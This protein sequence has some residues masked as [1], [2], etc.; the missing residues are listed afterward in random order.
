MHRPALTRDPYLVLIL[1]LAALFAAVPA[2]RAAAEDSG[3]ASAYIAGD[4]FGEEKPYYCGPAAVQTALQRRLKAVPPGQ[5]QIAATLTTNTGGTDSVR[6]IMWGLNTYGNTDWYHAMTVNSPMTATQSQAWRND[7]VYNIDHGYPVVVNLVGLPGSHPPNWPNREVYHYV[8]VVGYF[9]FGRRL[10]VVDSAAGAGGGLRDDWAQTEKEWTAATDDVGVWMR[11]K[12]YAAHP[13]PGSASGLGPETGPVVPS[14]GSFLMWG[15]SANVRSAP[16]TNGTVLNT[17]Q[18]DAVVKVQ[19]QRHAQLVSAEGT[20]NDV[21]SF[22]PEYRGWITNIYLYGPAVLPGIPLCPPG[23]GGT[24]GT[25]Y[26]TWDTVNVRSLPGSSGAVLKSLPGG[27]TLNIQCQ[28]HAQAV[29]AEG[30]TND[31]WSYLP[32]LGGWI[33]N[34]Y[35]EGPAWIPGVPECAGGTGTGG[36][37]VRT[38]G[39]GTN[40]RSQPSTASNVLSTL[41]G[42]SSVNV[43]C[44]KHGQSVSAE[45]TVNDAWSYLPDRG[46]WITNI[47]LEGPAW[48]PGVP[49]CAGSLG[50]PSGGNQRTWGGGANVRSQ[51]STSSSVVG[52]VAGGST[53]FVGC[54]SH[55]QT[56]S[57]EGTTND[58]WSYLPALNG[59][60]TNIYVEGPAWLPNVPDCDTLTVN[61]LEPR[62]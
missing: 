18:H 12:G 53:V 19:C 2:T 20:S 11:G 38:W 21:W 42:G 17:L 48:I 41:P 43:Q 50:G 13:A 61:R 6:Q 36:G 49:E 26:R 8:T 27:T 15:Q 7:V 40:V 47:Y 35:V 10:R 28:K 39:S 57:A 9:D 52:T 29:T 34:I 25:L 5:N 51:P 45:G 59:W 55:A 33:T 4:W 32:D 37:A 60:I 22:L 16:G 56:V 23:M 46:G 30:T 62:P 58:A 44:Q 14:G 24:T 54:Q 31:A 3:N 1:L